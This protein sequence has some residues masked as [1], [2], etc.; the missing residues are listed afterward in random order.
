MAFERHFTLTHSDVLVV[1]LC[2]QWCGLCREYVGVFRQVAERMPQARF[3]WVDV[4]DA[5]ELVDPIEVDDFPTLLVAV[6]EEPRFFGSLTPQ[7][8]LLE[9]I[10][11]ERMAEADR[12]LAARADVRALLARLRANENI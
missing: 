10:V 8:A 3:V 1:C 2:A 4:E 12:A 9:R 5:S 6:G 7:A 11:H